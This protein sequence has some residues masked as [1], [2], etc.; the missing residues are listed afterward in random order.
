[1]TEMKSRFASLALACA[2]LLAGGGC[3]SMSLDVGPEGDPSRVLN[4]TVN[5]RS[6]RPLPPD[7]EI[8]VRLVDTAN[9]DQARAAA[10]GDVPV[11]ARAQAVLPPTVLAEQKVPLVPGGAIPFRLEF[12]ASDELLRHGVNI[13]A[14]ITFGGSVRFRTVNAQVITLSTVARNPYEVWVMTT[15]R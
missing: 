10:K 14:R 9:L 8:V 15:G 12:T 5:F 4:G 13:E 2:A 7:A 3:G 11:A 6:E 1:M